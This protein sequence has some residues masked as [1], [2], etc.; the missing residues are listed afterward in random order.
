MAAGA[1]A[2][3]ELGS[4]IRDPSVTMKTHDPQLRE[5]L[6]SLA[7]VHTNP[8]GAAPWQVIDSE[9]PERSPRSKG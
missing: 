7:P 8:Q 1:L 9:W 4:L 2:G 5:R 6:R 3:A